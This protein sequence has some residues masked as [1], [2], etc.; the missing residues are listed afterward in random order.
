M[1]RKFH[2][3][4]IVKNIFLILLIFFSFGGI[5]GAESASNNYINGKENINLL[6]SQCG[7][8]LDDGIASKAIKSAVNRNGK[9]ISFDFYLL[10]KPVNR[11]IHG[12]L[13]FGCLAAGSNA[14]SPR[15][16]QKRTAADVIVSEDS[17]GRYSRIVAWQRKYKGNGWD[18]SIAYVNSMF[19]DQVK[20]E[21][22]DY[23]LICPNNSDYPCFSFEVL[24]ERLNRK[25]SDR[26]PGMLGGIGIID[27]RSTTPETF[28]K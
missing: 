14:S 10:M 26:I 8:V 4:S 1:A 23:F 15:V 3:E 2:K 20:L 12:K 27:L 5:S 19:G 18:G 6:P 11:P 13:S 7:Y 24:K 28:G 22:P 21:S 9:F 17:G 16:V 25:E